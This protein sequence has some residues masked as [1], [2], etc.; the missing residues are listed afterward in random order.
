MAPPA[1]RAAATI[2]VSASSASVHPAA[3]ARLLWIWGGRIGLRLLALNLTLLRLILRLRLTLR[4][5]PILRLCSILLSRVLL[6]RC[7]RRRAT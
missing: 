7:L 6:D 2:T 5:R 1:F 4:L 3:F